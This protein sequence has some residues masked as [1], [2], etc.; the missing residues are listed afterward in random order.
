MYLLTNVN[1]SNTLF[2]CDLR[3]YGPQITKKRLYLI[4]STF[5]FFITS[6]ENNEGQ[7]PSLFSTPDANLRA[8]GPQIS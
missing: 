7:R 8:C 2:F 6:R 4:H 1:V 3:A 5:V